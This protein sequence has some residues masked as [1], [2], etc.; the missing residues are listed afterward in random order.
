[1]TG[2]GHKS[3]RVLILGGGFAGVNTAMSL[4]KALKGRTDIEVAMVNEENY[5]VFQPMLAEV[6][7]GSL[8]I[9]DTVVPIRDLSPRVALYVRE[10]ES[11]DLDKRVVL[12]SHSFRPQPEEILILDGGLG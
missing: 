2:R 6:I 8:G 3:K 5:T 11:I 7:S 1:M 10:V 12:T 9:L 4:H